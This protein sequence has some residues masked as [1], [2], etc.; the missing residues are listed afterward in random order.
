MTD[1]R[2]KPPNRWG[3]KPSE[4]V[5][6]EHDEPL[7]CRHGCSAAKRHECKDQKLAPEERRELEDKADAAS[8]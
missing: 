1:R 6:V 8:Y 3:C 5:C 4:D 2:S 7:V